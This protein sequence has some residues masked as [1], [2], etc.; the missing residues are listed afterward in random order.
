MKM[1]MKNRSRIYDINLGT[2]KNRLRSRHWHEY[3]KYKKFLSMMMLI[4]VKQHLSNIWSSIHKKVKQHWGWNKK[5]VAYK[6]KLV[7]DPSEPALMDCIRLFY[8]HSTKRTYI[9]WNKRNNTPSGRP[10]VMFFLTHIYGTTDHMISIGT[11][12]TDEFIDITGA[13]PSDFSDGFGE[14]VETLM[15]ENNM[16][17]PHDASS[18]FD[19]YLYLSSL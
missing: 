13:V 4:C 18:T 11:A 5:S 6:K 14:F 2:R 1:K 12:E 15:N 8:E 10:D 3:S 17:M 9:H 16:E 19:L 7:F